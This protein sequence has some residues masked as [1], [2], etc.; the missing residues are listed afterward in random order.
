MLSRRRRYANNNLDVSLNNPITMLSHHNISTMKAYLHTDSRF[1]M[2]FRVN[3]FG[4][5]NALNI[6]LSYHQYEKLHG[7][8]QLVNFVY[9]ILP[10][11]L[12]IFKPGERSLFEFSSWCLNWTIECIDIDLIS[13]H[14]FDIDAQHEY[15]LRVQS[16]QFKRKR[17]QRVFDI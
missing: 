16:A 11:N 2:Q 1:Y 5:S 7:V 13:P 10:Q 4:L 8:Y 17:I 6:V 9:H 12:N 14:L 3:W 15:V